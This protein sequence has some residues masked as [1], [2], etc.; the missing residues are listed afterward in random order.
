MYIHYTNITSLWVCQHG[1]LP[2]SEHCHPRGRIPRVT[3]L[4]RGR[5]S[6]WQTHGN[7]IFVLLYRTTPPPR[8]PKVRDKLRLT[9]SLGQCNIEAAGLPCKPCWDVLF[10]LSYR[11]TYDLNWV[12]ILLFF[13]KLRHSLFSLSLFSTLT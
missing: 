12:E 13:S 5:L 2:R 9:N 7:V 10:V 3:M 6:C 8:P 1:C 11:T 4:T